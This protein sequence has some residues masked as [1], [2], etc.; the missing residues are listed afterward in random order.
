VVERLI[1]VAQAEKITIQH[2]SSSR[3]TGTDTDE[4]FRTRTG[5]PSA[6]VSLP[7]RCM[8]SVV[9]TAHLDDIEATI[10]LLTHFVRSLSAKDVFHQSL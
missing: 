5:V 3:F 10:D 8:H 9:E 7:L 2:E 4:I 6:L 1:H